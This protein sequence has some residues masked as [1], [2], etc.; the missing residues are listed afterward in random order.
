VVARVVKL[1]R[2]LEALADAGDRARA[3]IGG[4]ERMAGIGAKRHQ[5]VTT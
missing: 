1:L 3:R 5:L 2:V 4:F